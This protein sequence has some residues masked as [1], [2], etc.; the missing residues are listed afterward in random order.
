MGD[1]AHGYPFLATDVDLAPRATSRR[2][3]SSPGSHAVL[4]HRDLDRHGPQH[5]P[6]V[7]HPHRGAPPR[8]R[9]AFNGVVIAE[10]YNVSNQWDQEVDWFQ[11][12]EHLLR[13][14]YAW[15]G[16]SA[17]PVGVHSATGLQA[18]SPSRYGALDV[19]AGGTIT[20]N[21][22]SYDIFSQAVKAIRSPAGL[23]PLGSLPSRST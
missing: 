8:L 3:S 5:R 19:T 20:D 10:W 17:Q 13:E 12:H 15:V 21:S 9:Q 14:G 4:G 11:T 6:S 1:P 16:V 18:W 22:L 23:D 2:S 7:Q